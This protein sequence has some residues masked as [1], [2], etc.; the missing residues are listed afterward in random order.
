MSKCELDHIIVA[1]ASLEEGVAFIR[2][3]LGVDIPKGGKHP[4]MSTHNHLMRLGEGSFLEVIS[5]DPEAPSPARPRWFEL[6]EPEMQA[7]LAESPCLVSWVVRTPDIVGTVDEASFPIGSITRLG[8]DALSWHLTVPADG[9]IPGDGVMPHV[10]QWDDGLR[11]WERMADLGCKLQALEIIHPDLDMV[12]EQL[13]SL[14]PDGIAGVHVKQGPVPALS[15]RIVT[16][17]GAVAVI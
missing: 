16:P 14:C 13:K 15:A 17:S 8:R 10:I 3:R 4:L 12:D 11:P 6:D 9:R 5:I 7:R 1:A 2:D